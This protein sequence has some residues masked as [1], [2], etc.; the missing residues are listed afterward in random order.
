MDRETEEREGDGEGDRGRDRGGRGGEREGERGREEGE[1]GRERG[2]E[3]GR[4]RETVLLTSGRNSVSFE[5]RDVGREAC[6][7]RPSPDS[8]C[9]PLFLAFSPV[10]YHDHDP[11]PDTRSGVQVGAAFARTPHTAEITR[12][13]RPDAEMC[14]A[15]REA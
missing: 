11:V 6:G 10:L 12:C 1:G 4:E 3:R 5:V 13:C 9:T 7:T 2:G 15:L 14:W 8:L